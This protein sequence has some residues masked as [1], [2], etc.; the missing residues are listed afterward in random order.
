MFFPFHPSNVNS[1]AEMFVEMFGP[2]IT[3][4]EMH[5]QRCL[6]IC[7]GSK[8]RNNATEAGFES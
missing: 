5:Y 3:N 4:I 8:I 7:S 6:W 2:E 1:G